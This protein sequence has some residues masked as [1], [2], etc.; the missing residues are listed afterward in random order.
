MTDPASPDGS[1]LSGEGVGEPR[2]TAGPGLPP[3]AGF[4]KRFAAWIVDVA[5]IGTFGLVIAASG[6]QLLYQLGPYGRFIGIAIA[7]SDLTTTGSTLGNG[8]TVGKR[9][10]GLAVRGVD[11]AIIS[12]RRALG[13][14]AALTMPSFFNGW[15]LPFLTSTVVATAVGAVIFLGGGIL[16]V[17]AV[18]NV[19]DRRALHDILS[20][21][22]V[23]D[24]TRSPVDRYP[25]APLKFWI[26]TAVGTA[27]AAIPIRGSLRSECRT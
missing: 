22:R 11:G 24:L 6:S 5:L 13:R 27:M 8:Q 10:L 3:I 19:Y 15:A 9:L 12:P 4:W 2:I 1:P 26:G 20:G 17:S 14:A 7:L 16:L 18:F 21:T 25:H 23:V